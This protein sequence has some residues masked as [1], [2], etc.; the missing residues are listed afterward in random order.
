VL[1]W[2]QLDFDLFGDGASNFALN[3]QNVSNFTFIAVS[4]EMLV[5]RAVDELGCDTHA[6]T[7]ALYG[8]LDD[9]ID[10]EFL[11]DLGKRFPR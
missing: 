6:V 9:A 10:V 7:G 1:R 2:C 3:C 11:S 8:T 4:P 5:G